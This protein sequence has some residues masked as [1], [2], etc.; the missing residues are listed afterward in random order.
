MTAPTRGTR[1]WTNLRNHWQVTINHHGGWTCR[2]CGNPI[3]PNN[4]TAWHLGH[5]H[6]TTTPGTR[7]AID[8]LEPEHAYCNTSAGARAGNHIRT[9][10]PPSRTWA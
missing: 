3:P 10:L 2:R 5:P 7:T 4:P 9:Q 6:D 8:Q 1:A